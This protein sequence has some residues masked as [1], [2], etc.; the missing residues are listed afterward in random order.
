MET[1]LKKNSRDHKAEMVQGGYFMLS[2]LDSDNNLTA[3]IVL[4]VFWIFQ[5]WS[6][7]SL[8]L[9]YAVAQALEKG[10]AV[11]KSNASR[12]DP[13]MTSVIRFLKMK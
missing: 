11:G 10:R 4:L 8:P 9:H 12:M 13:K 2:D 6:V 7:F 1:S 5:M 3:C